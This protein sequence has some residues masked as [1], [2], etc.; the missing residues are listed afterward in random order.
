ML[1][2]NADIKFVHMIINIVVNKKLKINPVAPFL[3]QNKKNMGQ[4]QNS[5]NVALPNRGFI[6]PHS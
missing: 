6:L 3:T 4:L 1:Q 5:A 2:S